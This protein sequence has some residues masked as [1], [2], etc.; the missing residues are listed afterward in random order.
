MTR[1][2]LLVVAVLASVVRAEDLGLKIPPGFRV[3]LFADHTLANDIFTMALDE[4]GRVVVSGPGYI[5]RLEDTDGDGRADK[6]VSIAATRT[7]AMGLLFAYDSYHPE[8]FDLYVASEGQ[9]R[10]HNGDH[11]GHRYPPYQLLLKTF[12]FSE[13]G[14]HAL[15]VGPDGFL[16]AIAGNDGRVADLPRSR[17]SPVTRPEAGGIFRYPSWERPGVEVVA[18]GFRNPYDFD[19][20]PLG[21]IITYDSDTERDA[22]LPW[23]TPT[24]VFHVM[25]GGHHGWRLPGYTRSLARPAYYPDA[26]EPLAEIGRGSPTGVCCYRHTQFPPKYR[27]GVFVLDWTFGKVWYLPLVP[28]GSSYARAEPEVFLEPIG[29]N[30]FAPTAARVA[31]DGSLFISIGGRGTR[32]AVYRVEYCPNGGVAVMPRA[33]PECDLDRVLDA[34]QPQEAWSEAEW[35]PLASTIEPDAFERIAV[36]ESESDARR[37][38]AIEILV[39]RKRTGLHS[40]VAVELMKSRSPVVRAR[41]ACGLGLG[42]WSRAIDLLWTLAGDP[43]PRVR[44]AALTAMVSREMTEWGVVRLDDPTLQSCLSHSDRRVRLAAANVL[45]RLVSYISSVAPREVWARFERL[46]SEATDSRA[47]VTLILAYVKSAPPASRRG[48]DLLFPAMTALNLARSPAERL[49]AIRA[50]ML[51]QDDW[52]LSS[53]RVE[54][55]SAY[56]LNGPSLTSSAYFRLLMH[57]IEKDL[58]NGFPSADERENMEVARLLAMTEFDSAR[59]DT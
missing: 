49:D 22:L 43:S 37:I 19:F 24:R 56:A 33:R 16:Y 20:T 51:A 10:G 4:K 6:A 1:A 55:F 5:R 27:G 42:E 38:R 52:N 7:G 30:G 58:L 23:Y 21:D 54:L 35:I 48:T 34:P 32:G 44:V 41:L 8:T 13:H 31:P 2:T 17:T 40:S 45:A 11:D 25:E 57:G 9:I 12:P 18:H 53:P 29:M 39:R 28:E 3:T 47:L 46:F 26:V 15:K 50:I 14:G 59:A 36:C